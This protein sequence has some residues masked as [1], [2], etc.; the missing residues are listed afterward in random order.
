L[1]GGEVEADS[2]K[3]DGAAVPVV[4][5]DMGTMLV[6]ASDDGDKD[7]SSAN[8]DFGTLVINE[9][10]SGDGGAAFIHPSDPDGSAM[11]G[12]GTLVLTD[13]EQTVDMSVIIQSASQQFGSPAAELQETR[14]LLQEAE[15]KI[16]TLEK[17][18]AQLRRQVSAMTSA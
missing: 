15:K 1:E 16:A 9:E 3:E 13:K 2:P 8:L 5:T 10:E 18:N 12:M 7:A 11:D 14:R 6:H 4:G 17:E